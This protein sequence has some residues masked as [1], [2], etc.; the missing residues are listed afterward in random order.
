ME[1]IFP[2]HI[3]AHFLHIVE[4]DIGCTTV[5][6]MQRMQRIIAQDAGLDEKCLSVPLNQWAQGS[7]P[8]RCTSYKDRRCV[9]KCVCGLFV[10]LAILEMKPSALPISKRN[11]PHQR[12]WTSSG[13]FLRFRAGQGR[14]PARR[15]RSTVFHC[16][17]CS[18]L[19][20]MPFPL[21]FGQGRW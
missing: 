16:P 15:P 3:F 10:Y 7:S 9:E 13:L 14:A 11:T 21:D 2:L 8:W 4:L 20:C 5:Q 6:T 19:A 17:A 12:A 1:W 18:R